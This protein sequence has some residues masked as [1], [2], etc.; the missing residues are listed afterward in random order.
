QDI[1]AILGQRQEAPKEVMVTRCYDQS[2]SFDYEQAL[3]EKSLPPAALANALVAFA[4]AARRLESSTAE[5]ED[6]TAKRR[7]ELASWATEWRDKLTGIPDLGSVEGIDLLESLRSESEC[8]GGPQ[9]A[10][11]VE[12]LQQAVVPILELA[13]AGSV[14]SRVNKIVAA[15]LP[16]L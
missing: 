1:A 14:L 13:R 15:R 4:S 3:E 6:E 9:T 8:K 10:D 5:Q 12:A 11:M 16:V 2:F 7:S